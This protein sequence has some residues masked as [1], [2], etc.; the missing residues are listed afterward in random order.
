[1]T[2]DPTKPPSLTIDWDACG[3]LLKDCDL[4]DEEK[5]EVIATLCS[6]V[7]NFVDLGLG[8][9]PVQQVEGRIASLDELDLDDVVDCH[10]N[11]NIT[12]QEEVTSASPEAGNEKGV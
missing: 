10:Q 2:L 3:E 7:C 1:M 4:N 11:T 9:H 12:R 8:V 6:L 5:K